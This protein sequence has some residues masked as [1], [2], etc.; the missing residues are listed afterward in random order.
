[1]QDR[2]VEAVSYLLDEYEKSNPHAYYR[3]DEV[4]RIDDLLKE[5]EDAESK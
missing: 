2:L 4:M 5:I 3:D 1:M